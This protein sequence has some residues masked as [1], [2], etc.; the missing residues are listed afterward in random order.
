VPDAAQAFGDEAAI[1]QDAGRGVQLGVAV[2]LAQF[3]DFPAHRLT[4]FGMAAED[5]AERLQAASC[6]FEV[7]AAARSERIDQLREQIGWI[8]IRG[9]KAGK[10]LFHRVRAFGAAA[11]WPG[12][13]QS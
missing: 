6:R 3:G 11:R 4:Q 10:E 12:R 8:G 2:R 13:L 7:G 1:G 9:G 5:V